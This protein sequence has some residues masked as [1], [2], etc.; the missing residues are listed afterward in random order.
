L[1]RFLNFRTENDVISIVLLL[2]GAAL[3]ILAFYL[4][5]LWRME[6]GLRRRRSPNQVRFEA[7]AVGLV[8]FGA[9][10][11]FGAWGFGWFLVIM[12]LAGALALWG[13]SG[14]FGWAVFGAAIV[15]AVL[16]AALNLTPGPS[17]GGGST[18]IAPV[19]NTTVSPAPSNSAGPAPNNIVRP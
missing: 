2:A 13:R 17:K 1:G 5:S 4:F 10:P 3:G 6:D 18:V 16:A 19:S 7:A 12:M 11:C 9:V 15:A 14:A 8:L